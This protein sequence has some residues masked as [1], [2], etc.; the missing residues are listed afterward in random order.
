MHFILLNILILK[1][2]F[3][4][5][6]LEFL[7]LEWELNSHEF[8]QNDF[9]NNLLHVS[10]NLGSEDIA[11]T[12]ISLLKRISLCVNPSSMGLL[13]NSDFSDF[14]IFSSALKFWKHPDHLNRA[15]CH[16]I[17][18]NIFKFADDELLEFLIHKKHAAKYFIAS[19]VKT[20]N[21]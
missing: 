21:G 10:W 2:Q 3:Q 13:Y 11:Y 8:L 1:P 9:L 18:L 19:L 20:I 4:L 7:C 12:Y 17:L 5:N 14:P 16:T 6:I 15:S